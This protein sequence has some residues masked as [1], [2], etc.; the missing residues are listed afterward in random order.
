MTNVQFV[1]LSSLAFSVLGGTIA[2]DSRNLVYYKSRTPNC[3][4]GVHGRAANLTQAGRVGKSTWF[5]IGTLI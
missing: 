5:V 4:F 2:S 1:Y 3:K